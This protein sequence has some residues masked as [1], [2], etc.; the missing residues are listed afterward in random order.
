MTEQQIID[1]GPALADYSVGELGVPTGR[2]PNVH[3]AATLAMGWRWNLSVIKV[4]N[5]S[6]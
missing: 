5:S 4:S 2:R 1:L 6:R 3:H